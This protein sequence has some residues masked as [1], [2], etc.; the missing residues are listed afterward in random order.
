MAA[1]ALGVG[2]RLLGGQR[3]PSAQ[4]VSKSCLPKA[5]SRRPHRGL[6]ADVP[7][8]EAH[9]SHP[10]PDRCRRAEKTGGFT[11]TG[12]LASQSAETLEDGNAQIRLHAGR[13]R[14]RV[15]G[16]ALGLI[17]LAL[18]DRHAGARVSTTIS[19]QSAVLDTASSAQPRPRSEG[20][21][22]CRRSASYARAD[23]GGAERTTSAV[24]MPA[25][26]GGGSL[27]WYSPLL[28]SRSGKHTRR[29]AHR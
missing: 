2:D 21:P 13:D 15:V 6:I 3:R 10:L 11:V 9:R 8:L 16:V 4:A 17:R 18:G 26:N 5:F 1:A 22:T 23:S 19:Q 7:D 28:S 29:R 20:A 24:S 12:G 14:E 27:S 25:M